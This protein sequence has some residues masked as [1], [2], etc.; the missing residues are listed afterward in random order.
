MPG[1]KAWLD[2]PTPRDHA[3]AKM[4]QGGPVFFIG[5]IGTLGTHYAF[6]VIWIWTVILAIAGFFWFVS[7][8]ISLLTGV[9]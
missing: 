8:L 4:W 7:G 2:G 3:K 5:L 1:R 6:G 9:D